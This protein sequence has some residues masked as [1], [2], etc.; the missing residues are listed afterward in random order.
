MDVSVFL[1]MSIAVTVVVRP[2]RFLNALLCGMCLCVAMV[3]IAIGFAWV[4][5]M[6]LLYR[7]PIAA[8]CVFTATVCLRLNFNR[9]A[10]QIGI[11]DDGQ[12]R[13]SKYDLVFAE[14]TRSACGEACEEVFL[15][16]MED[17][18]LIWPL[19]LLLRLKAD[20][21]KTFIVPICADAVSASGFR[22][23]SVACRWIATHNKSVKKLS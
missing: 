8:A 4:S 14:V 9:D 17:N 21:K 6:S 15:V 10:Y 3:G 7:L 22:S 5:D 11:S 2:S 18:S 20:N 12:I 16:S 23:L 19:L 13:L 1:V